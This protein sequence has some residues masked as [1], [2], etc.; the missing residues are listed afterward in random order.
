M[1]IHL[2]VWLCLAVAVPSSGQFLSRD[3]RELWRN[4]VFENYGAGGYRDYDFDQENRRFDRFGDLIIDGVDVV[5]LSETRRDAPGIRG[6]FESRNA[7]YDRFFDKLIIAN[8]GFGPWS[9]RLIV[10][11][12]ISTFFTPMTL[13]LPRFNGI[14]WDGAS[15]SNRFSV[16]S[17]HITDPVIV[18]A[19][20]AIDQ[21]FEE[22]RI[23]GTSILAGHWESQI[24]SAL[25]VGTTYVNT[26]RFDSEAGVEVDGLRGSVPK[27]MH[28]GLRRLYVFFSDDDPEDNSPGAGVYGLTAYV[29]D[30]PIEPVRVGRVDDLLQNVPVTPD[31]TSTILLQNNEI[32]YL[33]RNRAWL[34]SVI[35]ASNTPFFLAVLDGI[36]R[37]VNPASQSSPLRADDDD[38]VY[39]EFELPDS[40]QALTFDAVVSD[41]YSIDIAGAMNVPILSARAED[42]YHDWY[43]AARAEGTPRGGS[44]LRR[45]Q[46]R[47]GFP[48]SLSILGVDFESHFLGFD[49][50]GEYAR[51]LRHFKT[52]SAGGE[53]FRRQ[54][55]TYYLQAG[56]DLFRG[57]RV[58]IEYFDVPYDYE[59]E[60]SAFQQSHVGPTLGGR[61]Y[62]PLQLVADND[63]LDQW[64]D[65]IEHNDPL[66]PYPTSLSAAGNGVF[67]GLDPDNDGVLD[68]NIDNAGGTD[69]FQP[70]LG[71]DA[72]PPEL[73]YGDDFNNNGQADF[74]ENDNLPDYMYPADHRGWHAFVNVKPTEHTL[75]RLGRYRVRQ[76]RIGRRN[77]TDYLEGQYS[78]EWPALG[79][80]RLNQRFK[81]LEDDVP[82]HVYSPDQFGTPFP[83]T[84]E[85]TRDLLQG[86]DSVNSLTYLEW[87]L[88][89]LPDLDVRNIV[90]LDFTD[91]DG[92][93]LSDPLFTRPGTVSRIAVVSKAK[94]T[95]RWDRLSL[96]P[97]FKHIYQRDKFPERSIPDQ[98][99]RWIMPILRADYRVGPRTVLKTGIQGFPILRET[100]TDPANPAQDFRRTSYTAF[101]EN[102]S[103]YQGYD[104]T[105]LMGLFRS[106]LTFTGSSRPG[107]GQ[108][109]YFFRVFIG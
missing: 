9:T 80:L 43:N 62:S 85:L 78:R 61:L 39:Y 27:V 82:D 76:E 12:H 98:Q 54:A 89:P 81:R 84:Y 5:H 41:D 51:S 92:D 22:R 26:H 50:R 38:I 8:E 47:Y 75:V 31:L 7:R 29:D 1:R 104:L 21:D 74:R 52:P 72:E 55:D 63:D 45:V 53:R 15:S 18:P 25:K 3:F 11:D 77:Y 106:K 19:G 23:F 103:N 40:V 34:R 58:G 57:V 91:L 37:T 35:E 68:F 36:T 102:R 30:T 65:D 105:I 13:N 66:A 71:Y 42:F 108:I 14:R 67:P 24:G 6:S 33:R 73:V 56:R 95:W 96:S 48:T 87:G 32:T 109:D 49:V 64:P 79:F 97:Q 107:F 46:F 44:N 83:R 90:S 59:T 10:G 69:A 2:G 99:R 28:D 86:R 100:S 4:E 94:Y 101:F 88:L 17:S 60:F 70:F 20:V 16:I 93:L